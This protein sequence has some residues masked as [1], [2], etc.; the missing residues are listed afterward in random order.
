MLVAAALVPETALLIPGAAGAHLPLPEERA[1]SLA[2]TGDLVAADPDV[3]VVVST[4]RSGRE[5]LELTGSLRPTLAAAGVDDAVLG[6]RPAVT[7]PV[8][9]SGPVTQVAQVAQVAQVTEV[10]DVATSVGLLLL[11]EAGWTGST[12]ALQI[13]SSDAG[14]LRERGRQLVAGPERIALLLVA[15]LSARRGPDAPLADDPRAEAVDGAVLADLVDLD[16]V[17]SARLAQVPPGLAAELAVSAWGPWQVLVGAAARRHGAAEL[18]GELRLV[19]APYGATY[20]V[21]LWRP[22]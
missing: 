17:A 18:R 9:G 22:V 10:T 21:V 15:S 14:G 2:A 8:A 13:A 12:R 11:G 3:V 16:P 7:A 19:S 1:A 5:V 6:W 20:A 4:G